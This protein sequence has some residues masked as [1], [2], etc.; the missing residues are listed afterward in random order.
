MLIQIDKTLKDSRKDRSK[1]IFMLHYI[2][3]YTSDC[4][5]QWIWFNQDK[6]SELSKIF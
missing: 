5:L 2:E 3:L 4:V 1:K 6:L